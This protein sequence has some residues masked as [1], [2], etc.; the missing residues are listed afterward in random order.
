MAKPNISI[1]AS[2]RGSNFKAIIADQSLTCQLLVSDN[3]TAPVIEIAKKHHIPTFT[4]EPKQYADKAS[5]EQAILAALKKYEI[6]W[7]FLAGYMRMIGPNLLNEYTGKIVNIHPSLL[8][9][10]PGKDAITRAYKAR[11]EQTGVTIHY[12]DEGMDTGPIICQQPVPIHE[13]DTL[14]TLQTRIQKTEHQLYP[15]VIKELINVKTLVE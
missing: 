4:F 13:Q 1:F 9:A 10:F 2:G 6:E 12:V 14:E 5:Y 3:P 7:I 8:P 11:S 15:K